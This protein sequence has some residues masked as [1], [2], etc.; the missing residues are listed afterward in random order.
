MKHN[1]HFSMEKLQLVILFTEV[2]FKSAIAQEKNYSQVML[3][4]KSSV[5]GV[6]KNQ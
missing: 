5:T 6:A 4:Q 1:D 2:N 3:V